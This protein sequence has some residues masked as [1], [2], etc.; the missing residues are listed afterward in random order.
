MCM[1]LMKYVPKAVQGVPN[2]KHNWH[3][4]ANKSQDGECNHTPGFESPC[5]SI[6]KI[7]GEREINTRYPKKE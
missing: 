7:A 6:P 1:N 2:Y 3:P 4:N 5:F